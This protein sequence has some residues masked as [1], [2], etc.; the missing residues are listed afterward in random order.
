MKRKKLSIILISLIASFFFFAGAA[1]GTSVDDITGGHANVITKNDGDPGG[2]NPAE[3]NE[4]EPGM[5]QTQQWDLEAVYWDLNNQTLYIASGFNF[6]GET[7]G[8]GIGWA[9][10]D[11]FLFGANDEF[12]LDFDR[13]GNAYTGL[14]MSGPVGVLD[15]ST[16]TGSYDVF[17]ATPGTYST[18]TSTAILKPYYSQNYDNGIPY[19]LADSYTNVTSPISSN[20]NY[21][22]YSGLTDGVDATGWLGN[23]AHYVLAV[24]LQGLGLE[25]EQLY[26]VHMTL[27]CGNDVLRGQFTAPTGNPP[28]P[29]PATMLLL[30]T[31]LGLLSLGGL[32]R[33]RGV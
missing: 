23:N 3:N 8:N 31:G 1:F 6:F 4:A 29:E 33:K 22:Y 25:P 32:R 27:E 18:D 7:Q 24:N 19:A 17:K 11:L 15:Y 21:T 12:A 28:V 20:I 2:V 13:T 16:R 5:V 30:A 10:G 9:A 14:A 26:E